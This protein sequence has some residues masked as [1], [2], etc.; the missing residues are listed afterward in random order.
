MSLTAGQIP[1]VANVLNSGVATLTGITSGSLGTDQNG[2]SGYTAGASGGRV[3]SLMASS[4]D[5]AIVNVY[6][7]ILRGAT[8][9]P[10]GLVPVAINSGNVTGTRNVDCLNGTNIPGLPVDN[11]GRQYIPLLAGDV[12]K[13]STL[14]N[15]TAAKK[16]ILTVHGLDYQT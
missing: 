14:V 15:V 10:V 9:L 16:C 5:T 7:Y 2:A 4:D 11:T 1:K 8:V 6:V 13:F 3:I 12:L